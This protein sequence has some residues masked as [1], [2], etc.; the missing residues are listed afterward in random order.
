M[1]LTY[2]ILIAILLGIIPIISVQSQKYFS[3]KQKR[4]KEFHRN[5]TVRFSDEIF[6]PFN[7]LIPFTII[8]SFRFIIPILVFT[9]LFSIFAHLL[10]RS[11]NNKKKITS[12]FFNSN[13]KKINT[14]GIIHFFYT[15]FQLTLIIL[16]LTSTIISNIYHLQSAILLIFFITMIIFSKKINGSTQASDVFA[17]ILGILALITRYTILFF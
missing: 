5:I 9:I 7:F 4:L 10:W 11:K 15:I 12:H 17:G 1:N 14:S 3:K 2:K 16:F 8:P 13:S 6:V